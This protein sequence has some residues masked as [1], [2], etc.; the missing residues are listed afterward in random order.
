MQGPLDSDLCSLFLPPPSPLF[1]FR[2][3]F[4]S[5]F[6]LFARMSF[7]NV[8]RRREH[9]ERAQPQ[10]RARLGMLEKHKDYVLRARDFHSKERRLQS[11]P[12][13]WS[14]VAK[15]K[16]AASIASVLLAAR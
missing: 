10:S 14:S 13:V 2:Q 12:R 15:V 5:S 8:H 11:M 16:L 1:F 3:I 7:R 4:F 6:S 9:R